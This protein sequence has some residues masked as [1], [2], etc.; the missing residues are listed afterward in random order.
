V[1]AIL[2]ATGSVAL[3]AGLVLL[4]GSLAPLFVQRSDSATVVAPASEPATIDDGPS[5]AVDRST[6]APASKPVGTGTQ[7]ERPIDGF[8]FVLQI[9]AIGYSAMVHQGVS[10][11]VLAHGPGHYPTTPWP[12]R[13]GNVGVAAHNVYWLSFNRVKVGDRVEIHTQHGVFL[14]VITGSRVTDPNDRTV[15]APSSDYRLTLTTCNPLWAGAFA[16]Q[17]LIFTARAVGGVG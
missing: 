11:S 1:A 4:V 13:L 16:T 2:L 12:G 5:N 17:R 14:Y 9:P 10:G 15:L 6:P 7:P 8:S 3:L